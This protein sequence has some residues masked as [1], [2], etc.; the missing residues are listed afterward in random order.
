MRL[1]SAEQ[2]VPVAIAVDLLRRQPVFHFEA[3]GQNFVVVTTPAGANRVYRAGDR[4]F[5]KVLP[6]GVVLDRHGARWRVTEEALVSQDQH[7]Q[8]VLRQSAQRAF[9]FAWQAQFPS[10]ILLK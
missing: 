9:W 10:T 4:Q 8:R 7:A 3:A 6:D 2:E 5:D 1:T